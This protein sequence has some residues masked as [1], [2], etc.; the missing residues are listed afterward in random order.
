MGVGIMSIDVLQERIRKG[1]NPFV[2]DLALK[3]SDLPPGLLENAGGAAAAY[4][5]FCRELLNA[6]KGIV[7]AVRVSFTAFAVL[8][9]DGL[10]QLQKTQIDM[11]IIFLAAVY[12]IQFRKWNPV[13]V[14]VLSGAA[15]LGVYLVCSFL[16]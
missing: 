5:Q 14:M 13:L 2:V 16:L 9:P 8:G 15:K 4:G 12:L 3:L 7:P 6:L 1:K 10:V 11:V